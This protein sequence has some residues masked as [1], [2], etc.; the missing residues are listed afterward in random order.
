[1]FCGSFEKFHWT[2]EI[3][4]NYAWNYLQCL[5]KR[6]IHIKQDSQLSQVLALYQESTLE[7]AA[8]AAVSQ[9]RAF[10]PGQEVDG[11]SRSLLVA[12]SCAETLSTLCS[13]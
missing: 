1:M 5:E 12:L 3:E 9:N 8:A 4:K 10:P 11:M 13:C 7:A 6:E 2:S